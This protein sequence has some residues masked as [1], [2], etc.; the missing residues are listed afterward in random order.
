MFIMMVMVV[1]V[2]MEF[3]VLLK[4]VSVT[5]DQSKLFIDVLPSSEKSQKSNYN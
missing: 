3:H 2:L 4:K 1:V 5:K